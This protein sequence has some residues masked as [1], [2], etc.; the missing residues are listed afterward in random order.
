MMEIRGRSTARIALMSAV[1]LVGIAATVN[2]QVVEPPP[3]EAGRVPP[4]GAYQPGFDALH[5]AVSVTI[6][7]ASPV[8]Q[9]RTRIDVAIREPRR[10]DLWFDFS[11]LAVT[12]ARIAVG[13]GE[14]RAATARA[15]DGRIHFVVPPAARVGD[16]LHVN[17][18][19]EGTPDDGLILRDN[20]HG[21][22]SAFA[23]NWPDRARFWFPSI[24]HPS[25]KATASFEV[26]VPAGWEVISNGLRADRLAGGA[27]P[28]DGVWRWSE[29]VPVPTYT[30][31]IGAADFAIANVNPCAK[32]GNNAL[33]ADGCV[34]IS[35]WV[36]PADSANGARIFRRADRMVEYYSQRFGP[37]PYEKLAHVQSATR[38]G[39]MENVSA[40]F[41]SE[42]AIAQGQLG[43]ETVAH[44]T[45]HQW[46]GDAV[47]EAD[48]S[49]LWL[50]EGFATYFGIQFFEQADGEESF[51]RLLAESR[52]GYF[53]SEV[54]DLAMVDTAAV[55]DNNLFSLL[56]ANSYNKGGQVLHMLRGLLG[57]DAFFAGIR[58]YFQRHENG[59]ALTRD[60]ERALEETAGT[61][62]RWFFDQW[63]YRP[64]YPVF[65]VAQRWEAATSEAVVTVEQVQKAAW[66]A[67]R[68]P[69][70]F[71]FATSAGPVRRKAEVSGRRIEVRFTLPSR[72][73][74]VILDPDGWVLHRVET[75]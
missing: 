47:T 25:D 40:I 53:E 55:P 70:E 73:T 6:G 52:K 37:F 45:T 33:H 7:A 49:H 24:D 74:G 51:Q 32:G 38:F 29:A 8:I 48:W 75:G 42:Q 20:V 54:T 41:Y 22:R 71:E 43:E 68:M 16:T 30:M 19:Y 9:G 57:D 13:R 72:P 5:Y 17:I 46:F 44:E 27:Q 1:L 60:L 23:D 18:V 35:Y 2:A 69:I 63:A 65:R 58:L 28:R 36:F 14:A 31:V 21:Q 11:G 26:R 34:P 56:N 15:D 62:L 3:I 10:D 50:S 4:H 66:P 39:G 64:G 12:S 59:T 61:D 67:F